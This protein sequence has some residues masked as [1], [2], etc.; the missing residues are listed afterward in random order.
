[1]FFFIPIPDFTPEREFY[2]SVQAKPMGAAIT[3]PFKIFND[4]IE[5]V[6]STHTP[7]GENVALTLPYAMIYNRKACPERLVKIAEA[8]GENIAWLSKYEASW[9][10]VKAIARLA[11]DLNMPSNIKTNT[12]QEKHASKLIRRFGKSSSSKS[13]ESC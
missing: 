12:Y 4:A 7:H 5:L 9:K 8:M 13:I 2:A 10:A 11:K 1:M 3:R 6:T